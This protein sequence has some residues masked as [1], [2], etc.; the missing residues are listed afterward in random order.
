MVTRK[1]FKTQFFAIQS[2]PI[3]HGPAIVFDNRDVEILK[4]LGVSSVANENA[5]ASP[6]SNSLVR[7]IEEAKDF[8]KGEFTTNKE[9]P[10]ILPKSI[11]TTLAA[12]ILRNRRRVPFQQKPFNTYIQAMKY[13]KS[14]PAALEI[15]EGR[16][17]KLSKPTVGFKRP[18]RKDL[19]IVREPSRTVESTKKPQGEKDKSEEGAS[20]ARSAV[21]NKAEED[22]DK[23]DNVT[24][25]EKPEEETDKAETSIDESEA[26]NDKIVAQQ[27]GTK[28]TSE[29]SADKTPEANMEIAEVS[30]DNDINM[31]DVET[32]KVS[33]D[34]STKAKD[35]ETPEVSNDDNV[36]NMKDVE[37]PEVCNDNSIN[38]NDVDG[39]DTNDGKPKQAEGRKID[40]TAS[41]PKQKVPSPRES[42]T[43]PL[44]LAELVKLRK[45]ASVVAAERAAAD[46]QPVAPVAT[47][48][49]KKRGRPP[50]KKRGRPPK[51]KS[52]P[53]GETMAPGMTPTT[54]SPNLTGV[55]TTETALPFVA[56]TATTKKRGRPQKS[57]T[58]QATATTTPVTT[59]PAATQLPNP[60]SVN[61]SA[62]QR[63]PIKKRGRPPK[64]KPAVVEVAV[65]V[66][67]P[68]P[69]P[70]NADVTADHKPPVKKRGRPPKGNQ[71]TE[72]LSTPT[73]AAASLPDAAA[74]VSQPQAKKR[75]RPGKSSCPPP[76][77]RGRHPKNK[78]IAEATELDFPNPAETVQQP[79]PSAGAA[80]SESATDANTTNAANA[81][82]ATVATDAVVMTPPR[83]EQDDL[84]DELLTPGNGFSTLSPNSASDDSS[85]GEESLA[86]VI[87]SPVTKPAGP[88]HFSTRNAGAKWNENFLRLF[89]YKMEHGNCN[90]PTKANDNPHKALGEWVR[91][92]RYVYL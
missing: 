45:R 37:T 55:S 78:T 30:A 71:V 32:P 90:V 84:G 92:Q 13:L 12:R 5:S 33:N 80:S 25:K 58:V 52:T 28:E 20:K 89:R 65:P 74:D 49:P 63:S 68:L 27:E 57:K 50:S 29:K 62:V 76:K 86:P 4:Q 8:R 17:F 54:Q 56:V 85:T 46:S 44:G 59:I 10:D 36:I 51:N 16:Q 6:V 79:N 77:K 69:S 26:K 14:S 23:T 7:D 60:T 2:C 22:S 24:D 67:T 81:T 82:V 41:V 11:H 91:I 39:S 21:D 19:N 43:S 35:V 48:A 38:T 18:V 64:T 83:R 47:A 15:L 70:A 88:G 34:D 61:A 53:V 87:E 42:S 1:S 66:S 73:P 72:S 9:L 40:S 3:L 75:G 31:D